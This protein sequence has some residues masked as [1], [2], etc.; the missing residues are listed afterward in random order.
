VTVCYQP[1]KPA[2]FDQ[3]LELVEDE[4]EGSRAVEVEHQVEG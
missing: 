4:D 3:V 2:V 1:G